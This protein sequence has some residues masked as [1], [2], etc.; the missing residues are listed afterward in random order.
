MVCRAK[1]GGRKWVPRGTSACGRSCRLSAGAMASIW[2]RDSSV[3]LPAIP[4][5]LSVSDKGR[6]R[7][8]RC[9]PRQTPPWLLAITDA[10]QEL[11]LGLGPQRSNRDASA[12]TEPTLWWCGLP[13]YH[14]ANGAVIG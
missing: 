2:F 14:A 12:V 5:Q 6:D 13:D 10:A 7:G 11:T 8:R 4:I 1:L 9:R 3:C